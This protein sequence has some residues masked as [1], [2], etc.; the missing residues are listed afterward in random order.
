[1]H[2]IVNS[3]KKFCPH[4]TLSQ[5]F[6]LG[7]VASNLQTTDPDVYLSTDGG[8]NFRK[9]L[10]GPHVYEI[11]D[12]GGLL[13]AVPLEDYPDTIKFSTDEGHC[14]HSYKFT[15]DP[16]KF[17]GLLTEPGGKSMTVSIWGYHKDSKKWTVN[18][19]GAG[20]QK[21]FF[22][23]FQSRDNRDYEEWIPHFSLSKIEGREGCL[24]GMKEQFRKIKAGSW[25]RNGYSHIVDRQEGK[26]ACSEEDYECY[27]LIPND[28]CDPSNGFKP[29]SGIIDL[30]EVCK[31][32]DDHQLFIDEMKPPEKSFGSGKFVIFGILTIVLVLVAV[33]GAFFTYKMVLLRRH[34]VVYRY[35]M[36]NQ[37]DGESGDTEEFENALGAHDTLYRDS[38]DEE[39]VEQENKSPQRSNGRPFQLNKGYHDDSD[40]DMLG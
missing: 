2:E 33:V 1:M 24:L 21:L 40:D 30:K 34:T 26:C 12:S 5:M 28:Q 36:L 32:G 10:T 16:L 14:W 20:S 4:L 25:C 18:G 39:E 38:S 22:D 31:L 29:D 8:Y 6:T 9:V 19:E 17:T 7:H 27:R 3:M 15:S 11:A 37:T 23:T 13:V 35:S